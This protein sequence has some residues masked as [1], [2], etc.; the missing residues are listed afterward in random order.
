MERPR[1]RPARLKE[2]IYAATF[3]EAETGKRVLKHR[4]L[5][6]E[7]LSGRRAAD[8]SSLCGPHRTVPSLRASLGHTIAL[9]GTGPWA[10]TQE[11]GA[12]SAVSPAM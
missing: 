7:G 9:R 5:S 12:E 3:T 8:A 4:A 10:A 6:S 1:S 2:E 11:G